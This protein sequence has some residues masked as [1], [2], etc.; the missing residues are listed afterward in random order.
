MASVQLRPNCLNFVEL[1]AQAIA[2]I[3]PTMTAAL[4]IPVM[5]SITGDWSWL[6]YALGTVMLLFVALN[7]NQ[8]ARR[9]TSAGSMYA[10]ICRGLGLTAG[11]IGGWSL[12]WAYLGISMAGVTGFSIFA[13]KLLE[14]IGVTV[15]LILLFGICAGISWF[16]AWK[17]VRLSAL[18]MLVLE[19]ISMALIT[20]LVLIVLAEHHFAVDTSQFDMATLPWSSLGLGVVVAIFSLVGFECA[21]AFG[22][23]AKDPLK[24]IPLA[25]IWSLIISGSF[26]VF[27]TYTMIIG[28]RGYSDPLDKI[29]APLNVMAQMAHVG[30][31]GIPLSAAAM[32]SFFALCLSCINAG[33]RVIY[34]MGRHGI[35]H[36]AM[37]AAHEANGTPHF[38]VTV[39]SVIAF[40]VPTTLVILN[41]APLDVF[42]WVG[43][44]AAF[45][46][47][48][49]Y[50][51][52]TLSAP[53][54]LKKFGE[55]SGKD[56]AVCGASLALL[57]IPTVG[58]VY[59]IPAAPVRYF[60]YLY[61][62]Y[63]AAG[64]LWIV[65]FHRRKPLAGQTIRAELDGMDARFQAVGAAAAA[66][67]LLCPQKRTFVSALS[68]SALCHLQT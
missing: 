45:G 49:P 50:I 54:Y 20:L 2:L 22:D 47:L 33:A 7:L 4:I 55:L 12:I 15:S 26:F 10:Y 21:T 14:M 58:S 40:A 53:A 31:L 9:S 65:S 68:M 17:N 19:V 56:W 5:Y 6:S 11:G 51:L 32:V 34:A 37:G 61:L 66:V 62:L 18:M 48:V 30:L 8:F 67:C 46:F 27:V 63:L 42:G 43:T 1:L 57:L 38:A 36:S 44:L 39:M 35:F 13:G 24:T 23:E 3:S 41:Q 64:I 25:V 52:I 28:T 29:D 60:P 59:P 16:L